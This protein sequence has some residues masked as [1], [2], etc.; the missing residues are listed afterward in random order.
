[1]TSLKNEL[2]VAVHVASGGDAR[3]RVGGEVISLNGISTGSFQ[4]SNATRFRVLFSNRTA[5]GMILLVGY[6]TP[7]TM[8][9][10]SRLGID[11]CEVVD[12]V[13]EGTTVYFALFTSD[14]YTPMDGGA[15]DSLHIT[16][17]G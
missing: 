6:S 4:V 9:N 15:L 1:M 11:F 2:P 12:D 5:G 14:D 8:A 17:Y 13:P 16:Y 7:L 3:V 10:A